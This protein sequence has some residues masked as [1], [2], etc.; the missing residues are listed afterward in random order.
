MGKRKALAVLL[1]AI[2]IAMLMTSCATLD[3]DTAFQQHQLVVED[4]EG[5]ASDIY[6]KARTWMSKVFVSSEAVIDFENQ[7]AGIIRGNWV[8]DT[9]AGLGTFRTRSSV[10]I[11]CQDG[12]ARITIDPGISESFNNYGWTQMRVVM[13]E[14]VE[15]FDREATALIATFVAEMKSAPEEW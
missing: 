6:I 8:C 1:M 7:E 15:I 10:S 5:S 11:E 9:S 14:Q 2:A 12:R 4:I 3:P 13:Q